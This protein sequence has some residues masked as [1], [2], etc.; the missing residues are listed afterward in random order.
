MKLIGIIVLA[1]GIAAL[2]YGGFSYN[3]ESTALK[4]GPL[5]VKVQEKR[6]VRI[7]LGAGLAACIA[8]GV[9]IALGMR[10]R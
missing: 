6:D 5:E 7:P 1:L 9:M 3:R 8:G 2:V 4:L 10:G